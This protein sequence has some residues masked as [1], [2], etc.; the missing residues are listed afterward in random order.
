MKY[1]LLQKKEEKLFTHVL[2][3]IKYKKQM[4]NK[5]MLFKI[6]NLTKTEQ[7]TL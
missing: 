1:G 5:E 7:Q 3:I 2:R 4:Y 6:M